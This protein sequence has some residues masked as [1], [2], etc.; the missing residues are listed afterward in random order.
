[1]TS[2][3]AIPL[4]GLERFAADASASDGRASLAALGVLLCVLRDDGLS[5]ADI[6]EK[7]SG[8]RD[9]TGPRRS[10]A[11]LEAMGYVVVDEPAMRAGPHA[12]R[13]AVR[14]SDRGRE[15]LGLST[16]REAQD[17]V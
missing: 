5:I 3:R 15:R 13:R 10:L 11:R 6:A 9:A 8:D 1:M 17:N 12:P 4:H 7:M 16:R 2:I 14:L